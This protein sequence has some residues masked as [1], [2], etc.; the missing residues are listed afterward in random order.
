MILIVIEGGYD[1]LKQILAAVTKGI[2]VM[3]LEVLRLFV[4]LS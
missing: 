1:A 4:K 2:P 3:V